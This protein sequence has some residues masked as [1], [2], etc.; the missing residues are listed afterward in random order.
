[1]IVV[2]GGRGVVGTPLRRRLDSLGLRHV[3]ISR[4]PQPNRE[5]QPDKEPQRYNLTA[6]LRR[7]LEP[8]LVAQLNGAHTL[9]H[10]API[11]LLP[12][13]LVS[14]KGTNIRRLIVFSSTSVV[15]KRQSTD[16][17]EQSLV[18][19]LADAE[20]DIHQFC[21]D[22]NW[23]YTIFRPSMIYGYGLDQ[24]VMH[25]ARFIKRYGFMLLVGNASGQRQP[26]HA[27]DLVSAALEALKNPKTHNQ[28]YSLA[29]GEILSY[30]NMVRRI[31]SGLDK[32]SRTLSLP[33]WL[34]RAVL[35]LASALGSFAYT[36][37][38]ANRMNQDLVYDISDAERDFGYQPAAFLQDPSRDLRFQV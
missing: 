23:S 37:E 13:Q 14:L 33:L 38:M 36:P 12:A 22:A 5:P 2:T 7:P 35:S 29:G 18:A 16:S 3:N 24:N 34:F 1:M 32:K 26:V 11:W 27:D 4:E 28:I 19:Q 6:D 30:Q 31:A 20:R 8:T 17:A 9:I 25:I 15:S 21:V 10:C